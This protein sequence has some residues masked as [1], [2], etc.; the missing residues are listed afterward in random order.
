VNPVVTCFD[1]DPLSLDGQIRRASI[2]ITGEALRCAPYDEAQSIA[3]GDVFQVETILGENYWHG[4]VKVN[5][6][7]QKGL[8]GKFTGR[9]LNLE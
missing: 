2:P 7:K 5:F 1:M 9:D 6:G 8:N 3:L 4:Y